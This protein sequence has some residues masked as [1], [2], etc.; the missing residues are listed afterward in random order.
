MKI[1]L[2]ILRHDA[3]TNPPE[4]VLFEGTPEDLFGKFD[5]KIFSS[6]KFS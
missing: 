1:R 2:R 4:V 5:S 6:T 3:E